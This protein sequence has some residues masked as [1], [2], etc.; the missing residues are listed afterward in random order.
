MKHRKALV[1][2][3]RLALCLVLLWYLYTKIDIDS[4][5]AALVYARSNWIW[6]LSGILMTF[7]GLLIGVLRWHR[8]L[9]GFG[10]GVGFKKVFQIL[11]VGQ[12][13]NAFMP[14]ACGGDVI[15]AIYVSRETK[16]GSR[17][18]AA[19]TVIA[20]RL[21][22]LL[23]LMCWCSFVI[24]L[25]LPFFL[26]QSATR[27]TG[28]LMLTFLVGAL[29]AALIFFRIHI[30]E[31]WP[32][33]RKIEEKFRVGPL[34]RRAYETLYA[35][36]HKPM[37][38]A[39]T[40]LY[41][42][43]NMAFLTLACMHFGRSVGLDLSTLD[44]FTFFPIITVLASVPLTP[45]ALG[46]REGLFEKMFSVVGASAELSVLTSLLVY[47]GGVV[48]SLFGGAVFLFYTSSSGSTIRE[49]WAHLKEEQV[50]DRSIP[51]A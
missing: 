4:L 16:K 24:V 8:I 12:F 29:L 32:L 26:H 13:F 23:A 9:Q 38:L 33:F 3:L 20:D 37:L 25:R 36:R 21:I 51:V 35:L 7:C 49:E 47:F 15:R 41:S 19:T 40:F 17:A 27:I 48:C 46:L 28:L 44:Y 2:G 34:I 5:K 6:Q 1:Q 10:I 50:K 22:G 14:G 42:L 45:G 43:V 18:E 31:Q 30:F 11:F 39:E